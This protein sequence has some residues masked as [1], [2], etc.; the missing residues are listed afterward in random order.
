M[1]TGSQGRPPTLSE[2]TRHM[3]VSNLGLGAT[4]NAAESNNSAGMQMAPRRSTVTVELYDDGKKWISF[5][6]DITELPS[7][8]RRS[9]A[10]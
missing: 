1:T 9:V 7:S 6:N 8:V 10:R 4:M 3:R 2:N 5:E